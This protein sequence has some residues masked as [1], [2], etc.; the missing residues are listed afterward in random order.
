MIDF[1]LL[2]IDSMTAGLRRNLSMRRR[3]AL[4]VTMIAEKRRRRKRRE[5]ELR[6]I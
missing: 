2:I 6:V 4:E 3:R 5:V 1:E